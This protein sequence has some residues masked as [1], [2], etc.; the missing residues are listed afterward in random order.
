MKRCILLLLLAVPLLAPAAPIR[1]AA[2]PALSPDGRTLVFEWQSDLWAAPSTGGLAH[3]LTRHPA[4]DRFPVFS[5]DGTRIAFMSGRDDTY[6][7]Y[8]MAL[9]GGVPVRVTHHSEGAVPQDWHPDGKRLLVRGSR[10]T[11]SFLPQ[12]LLIVDTTQRSA[13]QFLF[14]DV[15]DWGRWSPDG[16][17]VLFMRDGDDIYRRGYR[18]TKAATVWRYDVAE[19]AF[20]NLARAPDLSEYRWPLWRP[21][22]KGFY[23]VRE[24]EAGCFNLWE[25]SLADGRDTQRTFLT[26]YGVIMPALSRDGSTVVFRSGFDFYLWKTDGRAAPRRL[27]LRAPDDEL[28]ENIR[29]MAYNKVV[30]DGTEASLDFT[31]DIKQL[32]FASGGAL[33]VMDTVVKEPV[34]LTAGPGQVDNWASFTPG[35]AAIYFLR[36]QGDRANVWKARRA[37]EALPWWR[38]RQFIVEPVTDDPR[39]RRELSLDPT[40]QRLAWT[41]APG[42]LWVADLDGR[43]PQRL[44]TSPQDIGYDWSPDGRWLVVSVQDSDDNRD[45]WIVSAT[46]T[47]APYNLSRQPNWDGGAV[48][49]PDGRAI[50]FIGRTYDN[51]VDIY[52]A[53][54]RREDH[55]R[56]EKETER[57]KAGEPEAAREKAKEKEKDK[58]ETNGAPAEVRIDFDGLADRVQR[59]RLAA[60]TSPAHLFWSWDSKAL[61]F[62]ATVEGKSGTWKVYFPHPGK[63]DFLTGTRGTWAR[64]TQPSITWLV[65]GVP[66]LYE[67]RLNFMVRLERDQRA[68]RRLG[69]RQMWRAMR[70]EFY[71]ARLNNLDWNALR[72]RYETVIDQVDDAGFARMANMMFGELNASH[73]DFRA[74]EDKTLRNGVWRWQTGQLGVRFD[75]AYAGP[76]L[77]VLEVVPGLPAD[78][79]I[80]RLLAGDVVTAL[81]DHPVRPGQ[82]LTEILN[83]PLPRDVRVS[84]ERAGRRMEFLL[85]L[86]SPDDTRE[87]VHEGAIAQ[88][89]AQVAAWSSNRVGYLSIAR[90]QTEDLRLFEKEVYAQGYDRE[91]L[92]IDVRNNQGG[93]TA[94]QILSMISHPPHAVTIPRDGVLSYQGG[95][96][97]KPFWMKPLVVLCNA[98]T[99]SNGEI[100]SHAI[101]NTGRGKLVGVATQGGVIST[102]DRPLLDL[103]TYRIPHRGWFPRATGLDMEL[104]GAQPDIWVEDPPAARAR[105]EDPQ[106]KAAVEAVLADLAAGAGALPQVRYAAERAPAPGSTPAAAPPATPT[107]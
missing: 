69:F 3:A 60:G 36:D 105:G 21:D 58:A 98:Y 22:G 2:T 77:R 97:G 16:A 68:W 46:G 100:F 67:N 79:D 24:G 49:S 41:E 103:G 42:S 27:E 90:M 86:S 61:A 20:T 107:P 70:D 99:V 76:G 52:Y 34:Q 51:D 84:L 12:R 10:T 74:P 106:L 78:R 13:E 43:N 80:T 63:P 40:G 50:A 33:W 91:A 4:V 81:D 88:S 15:A 54:L 45:V 104:H 93:F 44:I 94:D 38:N 55:G 14:D 72:T 30:L 39:G 17:A 31:R 73:L 28:E 65:D 62:Q 53:W 26:E 85:P 25:R 35:G 102:R 64:W 19:G 89:R 8:V 47:P 101:K 92:V 5:P 11:A 23:Y 1:L 75:P 82:D 7:T 96:L 59:I 48:W 87:K 29:R 32:V 6:Q 66:A 83:G 37:D 57:I 95:Y 56:L 71:D 18:G 9:T